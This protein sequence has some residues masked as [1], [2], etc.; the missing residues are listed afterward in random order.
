MRYRSANKTVF[1]AKYHVGFCPKY[2]RTAL[3]PTAARLKAVVSEVAEEVGAEVLEIE[4]LPDHGHLP[5]EVPPAVSLS[6]VQLVK[7]RSSRI[8]RREFPG[9]WGLPTLGSP[10]WFVSTVGGAHVVRR[11]GENQRQAA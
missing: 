6:L 11:Y 10:S 1:S 7:G 9:L 5:V 4:V 3:V 2:R 8:L